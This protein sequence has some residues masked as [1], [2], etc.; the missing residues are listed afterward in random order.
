MA[1]N[2][3]MQSL[4]HVSKLIMGSPFPVD[5]DPPLYTGCPWWPVTIARNRTFDFRVNNVL[6]Y[7]PVQ[8]WEDLLFQ[9][10]GLVPPAYVRSNVGFR[11]HRVR[12]WSP[13]SP[14]HLTIC[15]REGTRRSLAELSDYPGHSTNAR[16]GYDFGDVLGATIFKPNQTVSV[17]EVTTKPRSTVLVYTDV[18]IRFES[19]D[20][21]DTAVSRISDLQSG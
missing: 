3:N 16:I 14:I 5:A 18:T 19:T 1:Y 4:S 2:N 17:F 11:V 21:E 7:D 20:V 8:I 12:V 10:P 13:D 15:S 9:I 6:I